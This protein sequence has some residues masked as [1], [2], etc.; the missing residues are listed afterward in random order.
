[1]WSL[2]MSDHI[3]YGT[4]IKLPGKHSKKTDSRF[5][6]NFSIARAFRWEHGLM[7]KQ[8]DSVLS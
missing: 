7:A 3:E 8:R 1:M 4:E 6:Q 2:A 5:L